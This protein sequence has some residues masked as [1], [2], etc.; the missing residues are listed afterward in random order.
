MA[1][2][3]KM[4]LAAEYALRT[5]QLSLAIDRMHRAVGNREDFDS[6]MREADSAR[7]EL[8][9]ARSALDRHRVEHRC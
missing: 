3:V 7:I 4:E 9:R 1:C 6:A 8:D 5:H 2:D